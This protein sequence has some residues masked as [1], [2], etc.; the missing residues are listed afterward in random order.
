MS[1]RNLR[2]TIDLMQEAS[3]YL[4]DFYED[5]SISEG[6]KRIVSMLIREGSL[7]FPEIVDKLGLLFDG[8][9]EKSR[10][11]EAYITILLEKDIICIEERYW[12][13]FPRDPSFSFN[14]EKFQEVDLE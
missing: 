5:D 8:E 4:E 13:F 9:E 11:V 7:T 3:D 2:E 12:L 14:W 1:V 6:M 10:S